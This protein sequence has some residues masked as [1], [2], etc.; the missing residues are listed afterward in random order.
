MFFVTED[1]VDAVVQILLKDKVP[2]EQVSTLLS[3]LPGQVGAELVSQYP[4]EIQS[5]LLSKI[6]DQRVVDKAALEALEK[7]ARMKHS[8][9]DSNST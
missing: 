5:K 1:N 4:V 2:P 8:P 9:V 6:V 3:F 7:N